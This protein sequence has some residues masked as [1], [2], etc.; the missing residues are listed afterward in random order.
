MPAEA[1]GLLAHTSRAETP[2]SCGLAAAGDQEACR[3]DT[4]GRGSRFLW[5][6]AGDHCSSSLY[7][8]RKRLDLILLSD[9][10]STPKATR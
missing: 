8:R 5:V 9:P 7:G 10:S 1:G 4:L 6:S 2:V 3:Q